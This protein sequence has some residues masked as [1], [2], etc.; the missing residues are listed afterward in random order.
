M[1]ID[2]PVGDILYFLMQRFSVTRNSTAHRVA[3]TLTHPPSF[4]S[5]PST[6]SFNSG[7]R[8]ADFMLALA[9]S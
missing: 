7:S 2:E 3:V 5:V 4:L 6:Q 8:C 9:V 1:V